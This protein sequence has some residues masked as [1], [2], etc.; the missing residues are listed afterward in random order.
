MPQKT[1]VQ[2]CAAMPKFPREKP[3]MLDNTPVYLLTMVAVGEAHPGDHGPVHGTPRIKP[4]R[5]IK[6]VDLR[7]SASQCSANTITC[8]EEL[9]FYGV[10]LACIRPTYQRQACGNLTHHRSGYSKLPQVVFDAL[11]KEYYTCC[12]FPRHGITF[13]RYHQAGLLEKTF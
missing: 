2:V 11:M 12:C 10:P 3:P 6:F 1:A 4:L 8:L 5:N 13:R 7:P 9:N